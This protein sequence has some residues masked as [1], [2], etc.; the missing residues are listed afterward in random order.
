M[1]KQGHLVLIF[2]MIYGACFLTLSIEQRNYD[3]AQEEK[4]K[5]EQA[6]LAAMEIT[7]R[8]FVMALNDSEEKKKQLLE[9]TFSEALYIVAG[10]W[11]NE[12]GQMQ[13]KMHLPLLL[14][15]E[16][17]G[18]YLG[19]AQEAQGETMVLQHIWTDKTYFSFPEGCEEMQKKE[20]IAAEIEKQLAEWINHHNYI[21]RQYDV[22]YLFSAPRFLYDA[23]EMQEFPIMCAVFQG[24]PLNAA[25]DVF[26]ENCIDVSGYL[27]KKE[28]YVVEFPQSLESTVCRYHKLS[29]TDIALKS[30]YIIPG[31]YTKEE[32]IK[33]YGA[34]SCEKCCN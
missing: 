21:S 22:S 8:E 1:I 24:W 16:A 26:Y 17:D 7:G 12:L 25:G 5:M 4:K 31:Q 10:M 34:F 32:A 18:V 33:K 6:L 14:L 13:L 15:V 30:D 20:I 19:Y 3:F 11:G 23:L 29:C 2:L 9:Q 27:Q 28:L